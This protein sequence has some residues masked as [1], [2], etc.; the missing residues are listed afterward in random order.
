MSELAQTLHDGAVQMNINLSQ[1]QNQRL[2]DYLA[3]IHKWNK[4]YN[5]SAIRTLQ[6]GVLRHLL[7]SLSILPHINNMPLLDVGAGAGLPGIV[8]SIMN[9]DLP[10]TVL[11]AAGKKCRFMQF[12]KAQLQCTNLVVCHQ[13]AELWQPNFCFGQITSRAFANV[14]KTLKLT[15]HLLCDNG[16]YLLMKGAN[17]AQETLPENANIQPLNVPSNLGERFLIIL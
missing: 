6:T 14:E 11:D 13:R 16:K 17:F 9:P 8:I 4:T 12:A 7:D 15:K 5:L 3:L 2:L 1:V 10:V